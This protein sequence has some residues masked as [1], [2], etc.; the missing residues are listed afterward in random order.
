MTIIRI[1]ADRSITIH[2][3]RAGQRGTPRAGTHKATITRDIILT[4]VITAVTTLT[5]GISSYT[6]PFPE[7]GD[8][9]SKFNI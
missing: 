3:E 4:R 8:I 6:L 7:G 1:E 9:R 2:T 5:S